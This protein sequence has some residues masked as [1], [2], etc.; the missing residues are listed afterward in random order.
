MNTVG[1]APVVISL[2]IRC[3]T[4]MK[5]MKSR[6]LLFA[7]FA[8]VPAG[9]GCEKAAANLQA[10]AVPAQDARRTRADEQPKEYPKEIS[11]AFVHGDSLSF[12][13]YKITKRKKRIRY[14]S[15][16]ELQSP[17][18][19]FDAT[20]PVLKRNGRVLAKFDGVYSGY[21]NATDFGTFPFLGGATRQLAVS[22]TIPRGGRHWVVDLSNGARV[23]FDS[24]TYGVGGEEL[25]VIDLDKD[26]VYEISMPLTA[27]Y[28]FA[29]M[30][31]AETPLPEIVFKYDLKA[32][33]YVPANRLLPGY[34]LR[35]IDEDVA[36]L[37]E[38][39]DRYFSKRLDIL[40]RYVYAG[41][42]REGWDFF[43]GAYRRDDRA[44]LKKKIASEL[45]RQP[46][47]RILYAGAARR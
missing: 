20:Y 15:P 24:Q 17:P 45:R 11:D 3:E 31:M 44:E 46:L 27:F 26:G 16:R 47:Y 38:N 7:L 29:D 32:P 37:N 36:K 42:E 13:G 9:A 40:L 21:G 2:S 18:D 4:Q 14:Y 41:R 19:V 10:Q 8:F 1:R 23:I 30:Y 25:S 43:D 28:G 35:G 5:W 39:T 12:D 34:A 33:R 22:L 6:L